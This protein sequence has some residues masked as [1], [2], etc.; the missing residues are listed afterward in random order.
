M[1][2]LSIYEKRRLK[3][4]ILKLNKFEWNKIKDM[5]DLVTDKYTVKGDG[6]YIRLNVLDDNT[7]NNIKDFVESCIKNKE[8]MSN[9]EDILKNINND[10]ND[11]DNEK[12]SEKT[13]I[14]G[15]NKP[16]DINLVSAEES[17]NESQLEDETN[18]LNNSDD[19]NEDDDI[20]EQSNDE[21]N[22]DT[23]DIDYN[24]I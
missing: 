23:F 16:N 13:I 14:F 11:D 17:D 21:D 15:S 4:D 9:N 12:S 6:L 22:L 5:I 8:Q 2:K 7:Q 1:N 24:D 10:D 20:E 18:D 19:E 3:E